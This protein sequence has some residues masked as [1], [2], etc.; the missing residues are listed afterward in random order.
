MVTTNRKEGAIAFACV[1]DNVTNILYYMYY[2]YYV[3][4]K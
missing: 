3:L 4:E 1:A 2:V